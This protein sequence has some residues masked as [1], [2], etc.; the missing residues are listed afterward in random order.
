[1]RV[2]MLAPPWIA[3]PPPGY[4]CIEQVIALL[5]AELTERGNSVT[6]FAGHGPSAVVDQTSRRAEELIETFVQRV[7]ASVDPFFAR[8]LNAASPAGSRMRCAG[9]LRAHGAASAWAASSCR[10]PMSAAT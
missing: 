6:L 1:M 2:A 8:R 9:I 10:S 5:T 7:R 4:G 3:V